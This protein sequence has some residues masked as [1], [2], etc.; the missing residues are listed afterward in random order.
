MNDYLPF[1]VFGI[2]V[3]SIYGLAAMGL[4]LT[5]KTSGVFNFGHGA[6][7]AAA[8]YVFHSARTDWN[9]PWPVAAL[10]AVGI[11]GLLVGLIMERLAG[12]LSVVA[13]SMKIVATVGLLLAIRSLLILI[14]GSE[15]LNF[16]PFLPQ[17]T[18]V[19]ISGVRV[20]YDNAIVLGLGV[21]SALVLFLLFRITRLGKAMRAVVDDPALL[22][23]VGE[24]PVRIRRAAW[25]IGCT[26]AAASGVL[27]A[28]AQGQLDA[29]LLSLLVVQAFGAA[30]IGAFSSLPLAYAGGIGVGLLQALL[31]KAIAGEPNLQGL[32]LNTPFLVLIVVLLVM[33]KRKL[34]EVGQV[35]RTS[36][37]AREPLPPQVRAALA[38]AVVDRRDPGA[39]RRRG[40]A[41]GV[42]QRRDA[43]RVVPQPGSAG[44]HVRSDLAVPRRSGRRRCRG[45]R[46]P[47]RRW[48]AVGRSPCLLAG[49]MTDPGR[50]R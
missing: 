32:D 45:V 10:I 11:F 18:L 2:T 36:S 33:P 23:M 20:T 21:G 6:I 24:S 38:G 46:P 49:A 31:S 3:G 22:D 42:D 14:Y 26:F 27:F 13:T 44:A 47:A 30:A 40:E 17:G 25:L 19:T 8:A 9:L 48:R 15:S 34:V 16:N 29:T 37:V 41:A 28:S 1:V 43:D 4:V 5:Y 7:G 12:G 35:V 50:V 39:V